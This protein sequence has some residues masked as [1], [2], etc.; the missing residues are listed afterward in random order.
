L[1]ATVVLHAVRAQEAA[2]TATDESTPTDEIIVR[3]KKLEELRVRIERAEDDVYARFNEINGDD[4]HDIHCYQR[5]PTGSRIERRT[6]LSN[7]ARAMDTAF[8]DTTVRDLQSRVSSH[9]PQQYRAKQL[10]TEKL[11]GDELRR[12]AHEDPALGAAMVRLGQAYRAEELMTGA[13]PDWTLYREEHAGGEG[14]PFDARHVFEVRI[15]STEWSHKLT[16]RTFTIAKVDG[17]IRDINVACDK[18]DR[19]LEYK[20]GLDWSIPDAWGACTLHVDAKRGTTF[21]LYEFQ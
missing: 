9:T 1:A 6:C 19:T 13:K 3:G 10:R 16:T 5:E 18:A 7:A 8:A 14:L 11:V 21:A 4:S 15:G 17:R 12:L 2:P 20:E